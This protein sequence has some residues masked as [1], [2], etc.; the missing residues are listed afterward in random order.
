MFVCRSDAYMFGMSVGAGPFPSGVRS[1]S[2]SSMP[3][4]E[5]CSETS[6]A[7][8]VESLSQLKKRLV[9]GPGTDEVSGRRHGS[10][11]GHGCWN[12]CAAE[13][14]RT[15]GGWRLSDQSRPSQPRSHKQTFPSPAAKLSV[16]RFYMPSFCSLSCCPD[17]RAQAAREYHPQLPACATAAAVLCGYPQIRGVRPSRVRAPPPNGR[18]SHSLMVSPSS[19][20]IEMHGFGCA[21]TRAATRTCREWL[22]LAEMTEK[23]GRSYPS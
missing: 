16:I 21:D 15:S 11:V 5:Q 2:S 4:T 23:P 19:P 17:R 3:A 1:C 10:K 12:G 22:G 20:W 8:R 6:K 7:G 9:G 18:A 14:R 13:L